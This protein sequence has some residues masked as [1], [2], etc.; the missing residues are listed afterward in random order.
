MQIAVSFSLHFNNIQ[1]IHSGIEEKW[2]REIATKSD[3]LSPIVVL[4]VS[5]ETRSALS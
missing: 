2:R 3:L 1:S 5:L 4:E